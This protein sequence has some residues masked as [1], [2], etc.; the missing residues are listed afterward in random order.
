MRKKRQ[1]SAIN[2]GSMA[3]IAFLLLIFFLVSTQ[4]LNE[5]GVKVLL[6]EYTDVL[7]GKGPS[8]KKVLKILINS[9]NELL[10]N[11]EI[12]SVTLLKE[13]VKTFILNPDA[14]PR[15]PRNPTKAIISIDSNDDTSYETYV[16]VYSKIKDAY[17]EMWRQEAM[18]T[19]GVSIEE[20]SREQ[21]V[22]I[23]E[24]I[25]LNISEVEKLI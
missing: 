24:I 18:K 3:D 20:L 19:Y 13:N 2:A 21:V 22:K 5:K 16:Q 1:A 6:P 15:L 12:S 4:I 7:P 10:V 14:N 8:D 11:S 23:K 17:I 25:P 9:E